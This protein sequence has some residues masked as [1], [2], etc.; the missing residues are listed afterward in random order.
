[1]EV[2]TLKINYEE[3]SMNKINLS[4]A[5]PISDEEGANLDPFEFKITNEGNSD[6]TYKIR[7][8]NDDNEIV[9]DGCEKNLL[10]LNDIKIT[11]NNEKPIILSNLKNNNYTIDEGIITKG[12]SRGY[13]LK[14]WI[15]DTVKNKS[16][17]KHYH[18]KVVIDSVNLNSIESK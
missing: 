1:M 13:N 10:D 5:L 18:G 15:R 14:V 16:L 7:I 2:G 3:S 6:A 4:N 17:N 11:I 12:E 9:K 8:V